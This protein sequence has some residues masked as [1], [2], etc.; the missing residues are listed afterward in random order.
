[1][2]ADANKFG[3]NHTLYQNA[4]GNQAGRLTLQPTNKQNRGNYQVHPNF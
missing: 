1:M 3:H 2:R 4:V